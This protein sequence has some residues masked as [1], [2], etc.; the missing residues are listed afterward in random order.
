VTSNLRYNI[1]AKAITEKFSIT[2]I[3]GNHNVPGCLFAEFLAP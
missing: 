3:F 1:H 2:V